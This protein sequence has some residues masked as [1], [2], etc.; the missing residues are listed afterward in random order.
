MILI[1][2]QIFFK[3]V[4]FMK[5]IYKITY[6]T[7]KIYIGKDLTGSLNYYGSA[8]NQYIDRDFPEYLKSYFTIKKEIIW[9][10]DIASDQEV[11][12]VEVELIRQFQSNNPIIGY[13]KW[14]KY[15]EIVENND[16]SVVIRDGIS[17]QLSELLELYKTEGWNN[18]I[19]NT[20]NLIKAYANSLFISGAYH[21]NN[22]IGIC[23]CV[24]DGE[25][26]IFIQDIIVKNEFKRKG[27][28]KKLIEHIF[29]KYDRVRQKVIIC[30][31]VVELE[32]FY[33]SFGYKSIE[34]YNLKCFYEEY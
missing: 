25:F 24:G 12:K 26:I 4:C 15:E 1:G 6:P 34:E 16:E 5:Y 10:T 30:D 20:D 29:D 18:Y 21:N 23:R 14:P 2:H 19:S 31:D 33:K 7:G 17:F 32:L 27:I 9:H 28:G 22:L 11:N 8:D 3:K 13:N